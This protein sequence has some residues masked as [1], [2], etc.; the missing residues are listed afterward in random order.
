MKTQE[1]ILGL[2][3]STHTI[4][5]SLFDVKGNLLDLT[6]LKP[7]PK[8]KPEYKTEE[9]IKKAEIFE[10]FLQRFDDYSIIKVIIE[11]PLINSQNANTVAV[12]L[13]FNAMITQKVYDKYKTVADYISTENAR[14]FAFPEL[15][16]PS[17]YRKNG[18]FK[19]LKE[20]GKPVLF[21]AFPRNWDKKCIILNKVS[22]H[23][24]Q[25]IEWAMHKNQKL[26]KENFD[27]AD[28]YTCVLGYMKMKDIW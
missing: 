4:G 14:K 11:E 28:A 3:I 21:G 9:L 24:P 6:H 20:R 15:C 16:Q 26:R 5:V 22:K 12:L 7:R 8:P 13:K 23:E 19:P 1:A 10:D 2:D 17:R 18:Q 27:A 25:N